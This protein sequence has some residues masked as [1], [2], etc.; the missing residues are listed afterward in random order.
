M[1]DELFGELLDGERVVLQ[2]IAFEEGP[3]GRD[4]G[5]LDLQRGLGEGHDGQ[6]KRVEGFHELGQYTPFPPPF[7]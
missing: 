2:E 7:S 4:H 5:R 6:E 1:V 3:G